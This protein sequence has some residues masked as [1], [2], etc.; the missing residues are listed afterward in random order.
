[1][2]RLVFV[3]VGTGLSA[4]FLVSSFGGNHP[5]V[6]EKVEYYVSCFMV[7]DL[8]HYFDAAH[9]HRDDLYPLVQHR[10]LRK[11][12]CWFTF[13][14]PI[15]CQCNLAAFHITIACSDGLISME[16]EYPS[17]EWYTYNWN[18]Q[19]GE[20]EDSTA[21]IKIYF[22]YAARLNS[23]TQGAFEHIQNISEC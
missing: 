4:V 18:S 7:R 5:V 13:Q 16:V 10:W 19:E 22:W 2:A 11:L 21:F 3:F 23:I 15:G 1:M 9:E 6:G 12:T 20:D 14:C 8:W 17:G